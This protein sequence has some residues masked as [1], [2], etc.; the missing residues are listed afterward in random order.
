MRG[1]FSF[2]SSLGIMI[3]GHIETKMR[4]DKVMNVIDV[5]EREDREMALVLATDRMAKIAQ[6]PRSDAREEELRQLHRMVGEL[7]GVV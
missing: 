2:D 3:L 6:T 7:V 4:E 1:I 5:S